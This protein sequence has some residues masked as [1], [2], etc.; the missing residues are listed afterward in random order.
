M[1]K[2]NLGAVNFIFLNSIVFKLK[3]G[4]AFFVVIGLRI[5][6]KRA[7]GL[8]PKMLVLSALNCSFSIALNCSWITFNYN[9]KHQTART[10][11]VIV[12]YLPQTARGFKDIALNCS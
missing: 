7:I 4:T 8:R 11:F 2:L 5:K 9:K 12:V 10:Y 6:G 1:N 3:I